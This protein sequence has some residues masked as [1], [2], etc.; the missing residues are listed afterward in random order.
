M[1]YKSRRLALSKALLPNSA[2]IIVNPQPAHRSGDQDYAYRP[3]PNVTYLC[4]IDEPG[5]VL[6]ILSADLGSKFTMFVLPHDPERERWVGPR[7]GCEGAIDQFGADEAFDIGKLREELAK[8]LFP[9][10]QVY[11]DFGCYAEVGAMLFEESEKL[12]HRGRHASEGPRAFMDV[13]DIVDDMRRVK[14]GDEIEVMKKACS[15]TAQAFQDVLAQLK[16]GMGEWQIEA[17]LA[18]GFRTR[19]AQEESFG[20]IAAGGAHATTL[21]Y[22][23][24][25]DVINDG[26]LLLIDAGAQYKEY[27][28]DISRTFPANGKFTSAQRDIYELV[29]RA[30][31]EAIKECVPGNHMKSPHDRVRRIFAQGLH[32]LGILSQSPDEIF[33]KELDKPWYFHG[34]SHYLGIDT[35]DVGTAYHRNGDKP[36]LLEAGVILTVEPGLYFTVDDTSVPEKYRGIGVRIEDDILVTENGPVNLTA[37][38]VKEIDDIERMMQKA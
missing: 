4:G 12:R 30:Q 38:L 1:D 26:D 24:N 32:D 14:D 31:K 23:A 5:A 3:D 33:E 2:A 7:Y 8:I 22:E 6:V 11:F 9:L 37:E 17:I 19:G 18:H 10:D 28:G 15:I 36:A 20:T 13:R 21:H 25:R 35:H 34:T 29:L 16:P 27:A